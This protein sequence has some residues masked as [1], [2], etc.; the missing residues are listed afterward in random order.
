[1]SDSK[2]LAM[3]YRPLIL[4]LLSAGIVF[5]A[6]EIAG[7]V[8]VSFAF[9]TFVESMAAFWTLLVDGTMSDAYAETLKPLVV[10]VLISAFCS[11]S[12]PRTSS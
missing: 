6:W 9:P 4:K 10:G 7:R 5:G 3:R 8:P 11:S 2:S 12:T 1:M